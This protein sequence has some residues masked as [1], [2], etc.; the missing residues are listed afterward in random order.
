MI[1]LK[2]SF[3]RYVFSKHNSNFKNYNNLLHYN[4]E[5]NDLSTFCSSGAT[6]QSN[7]KYF[8]KVALFFLLELLLP[9]T[10]LLGFSPPCVYLD[11]FFYPGSKTD[12]L[13]FVCFL[14]RSILQNLYGD[15]PAYAALIKFYGNWTSCNN[16]IRSFTSV[17]DHGWGYEFL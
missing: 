14:S 11:V 10:L 4:Y 9:A 16:R 13:V 3:I 17:I 2:V 8:C 15:V 7:Y 5:F 1:E 12:K 6:I